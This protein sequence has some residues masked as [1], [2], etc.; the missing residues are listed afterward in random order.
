MSEYRPDKHRQNLQKL[1]IV[2]STLSEG[3]ALPGHTRRDSDAAFE[4]LM[5]Q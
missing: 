2:K 5:R 3:N 4:M 1:P